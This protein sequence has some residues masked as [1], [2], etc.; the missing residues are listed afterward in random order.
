MKQPMPLVDARWMSLSSGTRLFDAVTGLS[1]EG[2]VAIHLRFCENYSIE[3]ISVCLGI[4]WDQ[5]DQL[6]E[7]TLLELRECL[8][9]LGTS[10][11]L[12]EAG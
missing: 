3:E 4:S 10:L 8:S 2:Q 7:K 5:A 9:K 6:I 1:P 12:M 11:S